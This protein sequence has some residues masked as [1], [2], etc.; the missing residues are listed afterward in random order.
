MPAWYPHQ[1]TCDAL[2]SDDT[3]PEKRFDL[4]IEALSRPS[5]FGHD[6]DTIRTIETHISVVLLTGR[7][8]YKIKKPVDLGFVDFST[9]DK[10]EHYCHEEL[11]LNR[12]LAENLYVAVVPITGPLADARINGD[13]PVLDYAVKM[14][15]FDPDAQLDRELER[16]IVE[17]SHIERFAVDLAEFHQRIDVATVDTEY[18]TQAMLEKRVLQNFE[19]SAPCVDDEAL[20]AKLD[21][22]ETWSRRSLDRHREEFAARKRDGFVRECHGDMHLA[23][24]V[25]IDGRVVAFDCLEFKAGLR[26]IDVMSEVAF[27]VMDL[28]FRQRPDLAGILLNRYLEHSGD[29]AGLVVLAHYLCYRAMVRAKVACITRNQ[30]HV[31]SNAWKKESA[32]FRA[33]VTLARTY[34]RHREGGPIVITHGVSGCGK[35]FITDRMLVGYRIVR[36]RSDLERKRLHGVR[37]DVH[38]HSRIG[39]GLYTTDATTVTY[40]RLA[41]LCERLVTA[42]FAVIVDATFLRRAQ[43]SMFRDLARRLNVTFLILNVQA[44]HRVLEERVKRRSAAGTDASEATVDVL[45]QQLQSVEAL[46]ADEGL[47]TVTID[48]VDATDVQAKLA[49]FATRFGRPSAPRIAESA[50]T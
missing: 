35:T 20:R 39:A 28:E 27:T 14:N 6:V 50:S 31:A 45:R 10:R 30:H 19:Q 36:I 44:P 4:L 33:H 26:W 32:A 9:L 29:Y 47:H 42:G 21:Q 16:G 13:G 38:T 15:Q 43:R 23:N 48:T 17:R 46:V 25:Y 2:M 22:I 37:R 49:E 41:E 24:M 7:Y 40:K 12:R 18:A 3:P 11:R 1:T 5:A 34:A 8:A